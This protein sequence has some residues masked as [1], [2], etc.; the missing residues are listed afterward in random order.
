ML[1]YKHEYKSNKKVRYFGLKIPT[2]WGLPMSLQ[3]QR[4]HFPIITIMF[5]I[6]L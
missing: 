1:V 2:S 3:I 6:I 4:H 5:N